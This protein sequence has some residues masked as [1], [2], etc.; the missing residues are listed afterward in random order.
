MSF[1]NNLESELAAL[2]SQLTA[3]VVAS[4]TYWDQRVTELKLAITPTPEFNASIAKVWCSSLFVAESCTRKPE[5]L[6]DLVNSGALSAIYDKNSYAEKLVLSAAEGLALMPVESQAG[7][8]TKLREFRRREM[9]RIAWRDL[10]GWAE[11][12]ETLS[13]LSHL[14]D[15]CIQ[16]ALD[17]LYREACE[18]RGTPLLSDGSP[19]Q[20]VVLGMGKLGAYELN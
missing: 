6:V 12:S 17:F 2:P 7:L 20:I 16:D 13:D 18:L 10:A 3:A 8:M 1:I 4:L 5:L 19:Q 9:V 11:L 14:A 15:A